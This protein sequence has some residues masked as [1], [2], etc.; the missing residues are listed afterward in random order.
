[1]KKLLFITASF[2]LFSCSS[3]DI[4]DEQNNGTCEC[5][6]TITIREPGQNGTILFEEINNIE[7]DCDSAVDEETTLA[8]GNIYR[9][10]WDCD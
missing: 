2:L 5:V 3:D 4:E 9:E 1:M 8:N 10:E 7:L 6:Q